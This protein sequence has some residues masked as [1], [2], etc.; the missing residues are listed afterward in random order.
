MNEK[1]QMQQLKQIV[2]DFEKDVDKI[3]TAAIDAPKGGDA[4]WYQSIE[5]THIKRRYRSRTRYY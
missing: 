5:F 4:N 1:E 2:A 3:I